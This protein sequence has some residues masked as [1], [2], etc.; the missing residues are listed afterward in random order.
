ME[1]ISGI[2]SVSTGF[3]QPQINRNSQN[4][5]EINS[6]K[7]SEFS[8]LKDN[9]KVETENIK[10]VNELFG[11]LKK[12]EKTVI[13]MEKA[14]DAGDH[15]SVK[16]LLNTTYK[17]EKILFN[18]PLKSGNFDGGSKIED[19]LNS[20]NLKSVLAEV[21]SALT[22]D[23]DSVKKEMLSK[24]ASMGTSAQSS[25][26]NSGVNLD[27]SSISKSSNMDYLKQQM[28]GLLE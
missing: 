22:E 2:S 16:D 9:V 3:N 20:D 14:V 13:K 7:I 1:A 15:G 28:K 24:T 21:K 19:A 5:S 18:I 8:G 4:N 26:D 27:L 25:I 11:A 23:L 10:S 12:S 17:D 6:D